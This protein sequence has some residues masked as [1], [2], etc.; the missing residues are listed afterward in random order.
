MTVRTKSNPKRKTFIKIEDNKP[1]PITI[2]PG[3]LNLKSGLQPD[4][5]ARSQIR[6]NTVIN[7]SNNVFGAGLADIRA[8]HRRDKARKSQNIKLKL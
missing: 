3:Q 8:I 7:D 2:L 1:E 4:V 6:P 5:N